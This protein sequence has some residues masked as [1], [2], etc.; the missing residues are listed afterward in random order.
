MQKGEEEVESNYGFNKPNTKLEFIHSGADLLDCVLGGG[1]PIGR[2]SNIVGDSS[3]NKTGLTIEAIANFRKQYPDGL[4]WYHDAEAAFDIDYAI[5]LGLPRPDKDKRVTIITNVNSVDETYELMNKAV[6]RVTREGV[7]GIYVLDTLD[8]IQPATKEKVRDNRKAKTEEEEDY[9]DTS[10]ELAKGYDNAQ[11]AALLNS[12]VT[13]ITPKVEKADIH[14]MIVSQL[15]ENIGVVFG[16]KYR[17][18]GGS[19]FK[20]YA[21]QRL[22]LS[23][24]KQLTKT[25]RGVK[26]AYG[27]QIE[28]KCRKNKIGVPF[29]KCSLPVYFFYGINNDLANIQ[30]LLSVNGSLDDFV[31][32]KEELKKAEITPELSKLLTKQVKKVWY[33][34]EREFI[35]DRGKYD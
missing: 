6:E 2:L 8:A 22:Y 5:T 26:N 12:L 29:R 4:I 25:V 3:T 13:K 28:A 24:I 14:L 20:Y 35:V 27:I 21:S 7:K 11:R 16:D 17:V 34:L 18:A 30:Y 33:E 9:V 31:M 10:D 19:A 15:R 1:Y 32:S 23:M